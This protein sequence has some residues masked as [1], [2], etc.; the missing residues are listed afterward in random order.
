M[1]TPNVVMAEIGD[2]LSPRVF[3]SVVVWVA[4][5]TAVLF[6]IVPSQA[7]RKVAGHD[8]FRFICATVADNEHLEILMALLQEGFNRRLDVLAAA[9]GGHD[10]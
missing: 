3:D 4:L 9:I 10:D 5:T 8:G 7:R 2:P 6:E 1:R